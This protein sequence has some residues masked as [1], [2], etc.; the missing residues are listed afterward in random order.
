MVSGR[1]ASAFS[2]TVLV[3]M[4]CFTPSVQRYA[5]VV[6]S[7]SCEPGSCSKFA[8]NASTNDNTRF[9]HNNASVAFESRNGRGGRFSSAATNWRIV[10]TFS[11]VNAERIDSAFERKSCR[12]NFD[13]IALPNASNTTK[14]LST[15]FKSGSA[16]M[17][18]FCNEWP[19]DMVA[20]VA[21]SNAAAIPEN[22]CCVGAPLYVVDDLVSV[23]VVVVVVSP[24][25]G[26]LVEGLL[27]GGDSASECGIVKRSVK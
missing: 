27:T 19:C 12:T 15:A 9:V 4:L 8:T 24:L 11:R 1:S 25:L 6:A 18:P 13:R 20:S 14:N 10:T 16:I 2:N 7:R 22:P 23:V 26:W 21:P 5:A 3:T 17:S